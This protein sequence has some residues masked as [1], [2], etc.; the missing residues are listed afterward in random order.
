MCEADAAG[1]RES[2]GELSINTT[3]RIDNLPSREV[4]EAFFAVDIMLTRIS[5]VSYAFARID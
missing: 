1:T 3:S 2:I 4:L 5:V